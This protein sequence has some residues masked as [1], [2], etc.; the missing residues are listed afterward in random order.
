MLRVHPEQC[1]LTVSG[2]FRSGRQLL[3]DAGEDAC[4]T[5]ADFSAMPRGI[6][7]MEN[8]ANALTLIANR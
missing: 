6:A 4:M 2:D 5:I 1:M 7:A 3:D 8:L